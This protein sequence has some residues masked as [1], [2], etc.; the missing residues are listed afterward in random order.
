MHGG[1]GQIGIRIILKA[2]ICGENA[3]MSHQSQASLKVFFQNKNIPP[4]PRVSYFIE[5]A[6][7]LL[8]A[9]DLEKND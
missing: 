3:Q 4:K 1:W 2:T 5:T 9:R 8:K 7:G 6:T